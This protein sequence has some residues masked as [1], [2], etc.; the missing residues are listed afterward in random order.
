LQPSISFDGALT[1]ESKADANGQASCQTWLQDSGGIAREGSDT[2]QV[3]T[4]EIVASMV[5]DPPSFSLTSPRLSLA[6]YAPGITDATRTNAIIDEISAGP[7]EDDGSQT[8]QFIVDVH[9]DETYLFST[10]PSIQV[11][12]SQAAM[13]LTLAPY[14]TT[15][16]FV[17]LKI[18][19]SDDGGSGINTSV[20]VLELSVLFVNTPPTFTIANNFLQVREGFAYNGAFVTNLSNG[21]FAERRRIKKFLFP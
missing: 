8:V 7:R 6:A 15:T 19:A 13:T 1:F 10:L 11:A 2:S 12:G 9:P 21:M 4:F 5:N 14:Q 3:Q 18:I 17:S 16:N 20:Q